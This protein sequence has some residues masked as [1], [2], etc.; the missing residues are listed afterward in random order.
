[1]NEEGVSDEFL[2]ALGVR[3]TISM[4]FLFLHIETLQWSNNP[5]N[6][7][8]YLMNADLS[9]QDLHKLRCTK[10]LPAKNDKDALYSPRELYL[11]N[12]ELKMFSFVRFLQWPAGESISLAQR[13]F[14]T[15]TLGVCANPPLSSVMTYLQTQSAKKE[16]RDDVG[17]KLALQYLIQKLGPDGIYEKEFSQYRNAKF[18]PCIRKHFDSGKIVKEVMAPSGERSH[19]ICGIYFV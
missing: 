17:F 15:K 11:Q 9:Q 13:N 16:T 8:E 4:E 18:L 19:Y 2:L 6:L 7:I 3:K 1:M 10:Y 5:K 12:D 14:L